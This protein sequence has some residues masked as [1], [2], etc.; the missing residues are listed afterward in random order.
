[1]LAR[2]SW[3]GLFEPALVEADGGQDDGS[4][5]PDDCQQRVRLAMLAIADGLADAQ[6]YWAE[7]RHHHPAGLGR[8]RIAARVARRLAAAGQAEQALAVLDA[9]RLRRGVHSDGYR[10]WLDARLTVLEGLGR[11]EEA[12]QLRRA[13][14]LDR[15]SLPH[16]R[17][18][19]R[20]LP[21]FEDEPACEQALDLVLSHAN[22]PAALEFLLR[23]P[24][25]RRLALLILERPEQLDAGDEDLLIQVAGLLESCQPLAASVCLRLMVEFFL[26]T[27]QANRYARAVRYLNHCRELAAKINHWQAIP[28]HNSYVI[29][30]LRA[31]EHRMGFLA[32]LN[33]DILLQDDSAS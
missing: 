19:L 11:Q 17:D 18:Y 4:L 15:L 8:P 3:I 28:P 10:R 27:G 12:Q 33:D 26:A 25:R 9:V 7:Y 32:K 29:N 5:D 24:D 2:G 14:A 21:A 20:R 1:V 22:A 23:W 31:Y 16:L 30:L 13:F 6:A